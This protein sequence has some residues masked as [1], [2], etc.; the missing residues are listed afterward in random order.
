MT[1]THLT[2]EQLSAHLDG[3]EN[4][5]EPLTDPGSGASVVREHLSTC[6]TCR[7]RLA[8]FEDVRELVRTPVPPVSSD[9]RAAAVADALREARVSAAAV[10]GQQAG[11]ESTEPI[12]L[13][14]RVRPRVLAGAAAALVVA[15]SIGILAVTGLTSSTSSTSSSRS[16]PTRTSPNSALHR[17]APSLGAIVSG[18]D[19]GSIGSR[20]QLR[21]RLSTSIDGLNKNSTSAGAG[22]ASGAGGFSAGAPATPSPARASAGQSARAEV[23]MCVGTAIHTANGNRTL[24]FTATLN[25]RSTPAIVYVFGAVSGASQGSPARSMAVVTAATGCRVLVTTSL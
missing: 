1:Q 10:D 12:R 15:G 19:L 7:A 4:G 6:D 13:R 3:A 22:S 16:T 24:E 11:R 5:A 9:T 18:G 25:Y 21:S 17:P 14:H 23:Y 8:N 2:D 20:Q